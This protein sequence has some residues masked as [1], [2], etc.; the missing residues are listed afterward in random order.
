MN[1]KD[2]FLYY[3]NDEALSEDIAEI[4]K[5]MGSVTEAELLLWENGTDD[6]NGKITSSW[7]ELVL[8]LRKVW[9]N[10]SRVEIVKIAT[11]QYGFDDIQTEGQRV[12]KIIKKRFPNLPLHSNLRRFKF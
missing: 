9:D 11:A 5:S 7:I 6:E 4:I 3:D 1:M 10:H 8:S 2:I 12:K